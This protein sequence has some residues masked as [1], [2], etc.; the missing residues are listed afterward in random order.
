MRQT[1]TKYKRID[2]REA[3]KRFNRGEVIIVVGDNVN[4]YH[5]FSGWHLAQ[6]IEKTEDR[7]DFDSWINNFEFYLEPELGKRAAFFTDTTA[8]R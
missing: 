4:D 7:N 8:L 3:R 5:F 1:S 6:R 2:K